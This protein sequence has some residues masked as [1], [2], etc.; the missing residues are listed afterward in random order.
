M[1]CYDSRTPDPNRTIEQLRR[2]I[3]E[4]TRVCCDMRTIIRRAGL[5]EDLTVEARTWIARHDSEDEKRIREEK[6]SGL[7][8]S[9]RQETLD[10]LSLEERRVLGL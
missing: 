3:N 5:E 10:K 4:V 2:D 9:L 1:P 6:A 7:R 8:D